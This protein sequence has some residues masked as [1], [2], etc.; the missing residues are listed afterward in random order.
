VVAEL[1]A[2]STTPGT[3]V[4]R[5]EQGPGYFQKGYPGYTANDVYILR[6]IDLA[7]GSSK[8]IVSANKA[9]CPTVYQAFNTLNL[10][11]DSC[12]SAD[13][14][15]TLSN[16]NQVRIVDLVIGNTLDDEVV[17]TGLMKFDAKN[18][19]VYTLHDVKVTGCHF[20]RYEG[21]FIE[22][23]DHPLSVPV[24]DFQDPFV[25]CLLTNKK[26]FTLNGN[27]F[28]DYDGECIDDKF[29]QTAN[30]TKETVH[31]YLDNGLHADTGIPLANGLSRALSEIQVNEV[32]LGG[33][34]VLGLVKIDGRNL[35]GI[36]AYSMAGQEI[37]STPNLD[38][39]IEG[40]PIDLSNP[41]E[42]DFLYHLITTTGDFYL[43]NGLKI[44]DYNY[45]IDRYRE[46]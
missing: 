1:S 27:C 26:E 12:F 30:T 31:F 14:L 8:C 21:H 2:T 45:G 3:I 20:V 4:Y 9:D 15:F 29:M 33:I 36:Y 22:V 18:L 41:V 42:H 6:N 43:G 35:N 19:Q 16:K 7:K 10:R 17:I 32:L 11:Y 13:T 24:L 5:L 39:G 34:R 40:A 44:K 46:L 25:Y 38:F 37:I 23:C 28:A